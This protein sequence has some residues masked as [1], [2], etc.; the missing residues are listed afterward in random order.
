MR[1]ESANVLRAVQDSKPRQELAEDHE[2]QA[3]WVTGCTAHKKAMN[4]S[5]LAGVNQYTANNVNHTHSPIVRV[6]SS[7]QSAQLRLSAQLRCD[8]K[9]LHT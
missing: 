5:V 2:V 3:R 8:A 1:V 9:L 4:E 7:K 6:D